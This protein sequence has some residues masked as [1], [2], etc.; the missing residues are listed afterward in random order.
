M[1]YFTAWADKGVQQRGA[2]A[3]LEVTEAEQK[4]YLVDNSELK[5]RSRGIRYRRFPSLEYKDMQLKPAPFGTVV[6][7][8]RCHGDWLCVGGRFLPLALQGRAVLRPLAGQGGEAPA[9][10]GAPEAAP[11]SEEDTTDAAYNTRLGDKPAWLLGRR[12]SCLPV[13]DFDSAVKLE[14]EAAATVEGVQHSAHMGDLYVVV[15][16][17][18]KVRQS[19]SEDALVENFKSKG[20]IVELFEWDETKA[21]RRCLDAGVRPGTAGWMMLSHPTHGPLLARLEPVCMAAARGSLPD[22][23]RCLRGVN[24]R[25]WRGFSGCDPLRLAAQR[26]FLDCCVLLLQAG[27]D[28]A[29]ILQDGFQL[30]WKVEGGMR[31]AL[32][33]ALTGKNF[34]VPQLEAALARLPQEAR[35]AAEALF[36]KAAAQLE[37]CRAAAASDGEGEGEYE[38]EGEGREAATAAGAVAQGHEKPCT[39]AEAESAE[40]EVAAQGEAPPSASAG[41]PRRRPS[42]GGQRCAGAL[43]RVLPAR[44]PVRHEPSLEADVIGI[45]LSG[46]VVE[47]LE[48]DRTRRWRK[49]QMGVEPFL[50]EPRRSGWMLL[51]H[52]RLGTLLEPCEADLSVS[53]EATDE[54]ATD[55]E[56]ERRRDSWEQLFARK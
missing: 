50:N 5:S 10:G 20:E 3:A 53:G 1:G 52:P 43:H 46:Q 42:A 41:D 19:P 7:G 37:A 54:E 30:P 44:V 28:V 26:G 55:E 6:R 15:A 2:G 14:V 8:F 11:E 48:H 23:K 25:G 17:N 24:L 32:F 34:E 40:E 27:A 49:V 35:E 21:W 51:Q 39:W 18:V 47:M 38:G 9:E 33:A 12:E 31:E 56:E 4:P 22:L 45:R 16:A 29:L 36:D 13:E